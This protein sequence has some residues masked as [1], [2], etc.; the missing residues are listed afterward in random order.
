MS[1]KLNPKI[2]I[3]S[4]QMK[5]EIRN[6]L[7]EVVDE[8][9]VSLDFEID[10]PVLDI[11][12]VGSNAGYNYNE[13]SDI[14]LHIVTDFTQLCGC[15]EVVQQLFN[16]ERSIF[17]KSYD[18][19]FKGVEVELYVEDVNASTVSN[20]VY[21]V[22]RDGWV[23]RPQIPVFTAELDTAS[24][25]WRDTYELATSLLTNG[26]VDEIREFLNGLYLMRKYSILS[27]GEYSQGN[28]IFKELRNLGI[29]DQLKERLVSVR[30]K[31]LSIESLRLIEGAQIEVPELRDESEKYI[32][33][34]VRDSEGSIRK[35]LD[36]ISSLAKRGHSFPVEV[37]PH[38][39]ENK[40]SFFI[41][42]DGVDSIL[43]IT[44]EEFS[45]DEE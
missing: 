9:L 1:E 6:K 39:S 14:D 43:S 16:A 22:L 15:T 3:N 38:D 25:A 34:V 12:L 18:I 33:L 30:S 5:P 26:S 23:V 7:L 11:I 40:Q 32:T 24:D 42:G 21:S 28:L 35:M 8:F 17:N 45:G 2:F 37:D 20:G 31:E 36:Y 29:I 44:E 4:D 19:K 13:H 27:D 41:D 10:F